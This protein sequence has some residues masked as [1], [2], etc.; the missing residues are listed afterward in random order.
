MSINVG[1]M[2]TDMTVVDGELP[3]NERQVEKLV[4][5]ILKRLDSM[6]RDEEKSK[7][8]TSLNRSNAP[9]ARVGE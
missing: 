1:E 4:Q 5:V 2:N 7:D 3:L 8:A 6:K 9:P